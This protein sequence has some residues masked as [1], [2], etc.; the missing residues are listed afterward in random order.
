LNE[1]GQIAGT[2][3]TA[4]GEA[5]AALWI[6]TSGPLAMAPAEGDAEAESR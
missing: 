1:F 6:P 2:S 3:V 4:A 5:R